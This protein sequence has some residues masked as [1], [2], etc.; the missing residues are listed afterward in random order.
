[1]AHSLVKHVLP[2]WDN[3]VGQWQIKP[4]EAKVERLLS[5]FQYRTVR[6]N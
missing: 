4:V 1:M 3:I 6:V 2:I 5:T